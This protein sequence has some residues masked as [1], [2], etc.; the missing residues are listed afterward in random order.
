MTRWSSQLV[1]GPYI[2]STA[3]FVAP[4]DNYKPDLTT[5]PY[6][7]PLPTTRQAA[8]IS[9]Q[10][11]SL[12]NALVNPGQ[13]PSCPY[14]PS[15]PTAV[16]DCTGPIG[17][18]SWYLKNPTSVSSTAADSPSDLI[19]FT[20]G[21]VE[22]AAYEGCPNTVNTETFVC[23]DSDGIYYGWEA[24]NMAL[25]SS[26]GSPD[27]NM[28]KAWRPYANQSN[29][30]FSDTHAKTLP[31]GKLTIGTLLNPRYWLVTIPAGY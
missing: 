27:P 23:D 20:E 21:G 6:E 30:S 15:L 14:F 10:A 19:M 2:K 7:Q 29:F 28:A 5:Y 18:G 3:I 31:P 24:L 16:A 13:A 17:P 8:P 11:N 22:N 26:F 25:G 12:S 1:L 4:I 9:Y